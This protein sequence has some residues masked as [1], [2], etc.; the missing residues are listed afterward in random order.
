MTRAK[1]VPQLKHID[2]KLNQNYMV[3]AESLHQ[4]KFSAVQYSDLSIIE[5]E[6]KI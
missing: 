5:N 6:R 4:S 1:I 3:C 2:L